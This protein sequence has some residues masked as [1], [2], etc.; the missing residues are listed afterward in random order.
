[1]RFTSP[2]VSK[3]LHLKQG[4]MLVWLDTRR[5]SPLWGDLRQFWSWLS[6]QPFPKVTP[7]AMTKDDDNNIHKL[8]SL[9]TFPHPPDSTRIDY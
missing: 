6:S 7:P 5:A 2:S 9:E 4:S 3:K 8:L 1:M